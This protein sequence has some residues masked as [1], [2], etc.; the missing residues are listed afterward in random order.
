MLEFPSLHQGADY[1]TLDPVV[2]TAKMMGIQLED[3]PVLSPTILADVG[4]KSREELANLFLQ[5]EKIIKAREAG[6]QPCLLPRN[7][8]HICA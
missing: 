4:Q 7:V 6:T 5:A 3:E 8:A 2:A 1:D